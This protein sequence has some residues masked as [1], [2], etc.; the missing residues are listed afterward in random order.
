MVILGLNTVGQTCEAALLRDGA[1]LADA[2]ETP[3]E[4]AA[5]R[6][7]PLA[8]ELLRSA[9]LG[10]PDIDR[11]AVVAGPGSFTGVRVGVAFARGLALALDRPAVGLTTLE[12]CLPPGEMRSCLVLL[13]AKR[14]PPERSWWA[15]VFREGRPE[16]EPEELNETEATIATTRVEVVIGSDWGTPGR[17]AA[18]PSA[19]NAALR[20]AGR[21]VTDCEAPRPVYVRAPD[22]RPMAGPAVAQGAGDER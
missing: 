20:A 3:A 4:G 10:W 22:A 13:P 6:L 21:D 17:L 8:E 11:I 18:G 7:A 2:R 1:V 9:G 15:Q 12:V 5:A 19:L 16:G 14:R